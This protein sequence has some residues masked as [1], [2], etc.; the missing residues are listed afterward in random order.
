MFDQICPHLATGRH[1]V[2]H[3]RWKARLDDRLGE[4]QA[5]E[6][7]LRARLH[8]D[9]TPGREQRSELEHREGLWVVPRHYRADDS[10]GLAQNMNRAAEEARPILLQRGLADQPRVV[11]RHHGRKDGLDL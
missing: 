9:G 11:A 3:T 6:H 5:V 1:D 2:H 10:D 7:R 4:Q 8:H